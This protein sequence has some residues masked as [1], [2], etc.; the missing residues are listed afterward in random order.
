[1]HFSVGLWNIISSISM[2]S[3][4]L[5]KSE[6]QYEL[7]IRGR[8]SEGTVEELRRRLNQCFSAEVDVDQ[9]V[10]NDL[11]VELELEDC[12]EK[13]QD[14][15]TLTEEYDGDGKDRECQRLIA[16]LWH[17]SMRIERIPVAATA[18]DEMERKKSSLLHRTTPLLDKMKNFP[19]R[20]LSPLPDN[21]GRED[22]DSTMSEEKRLT[23]TTGLR[24]ASTIAT[25]NQAKPMKTT[26]TINTPSLGQAPEQIE[27]SERYEPNRI[28]QHNQ[29]LPVD[30]DYR[31]KAVPVYKWGLKFGNER[32]QSVAA[33]LQ[34]VEELRRSRGVSTREL[35]N[36]AVDL[37]SGSALVWYRSTLGRIFSWEELCVEMRIV[38]QSPD[39]EI[40]LQQE[41]FNRVQGDNESID[42][43]IASM[44]G[45]YSRLEEDIPEQTKLKQISH[46]LHPQL[47]DRIALFEVHTIE[48][49]RRLGRKAEMGRLRSATTRSSIGSNRHA[50]EPD[51]AYN[52]HPGRRENPPR[53]IASIQHSG[54]QPM[55]C[56][57]CKVTGHR[58]SD[59]DKKRGKF[60]FSCG[61]PGVIKAN[62]SKCHSKNV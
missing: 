12:E 54:K 62:C 45:L 48:Q 40:R 60:C 22:E 52:D 47:Q 1:M 19:Q 56:W 18:D 42:L 55:K 5:R 50:I 20:G 6:I 58:F 28:F 49:L 17:L 27:R 36:S 8:S 13:Y 39:H 21:Y 14:L 41:I 9:R 31:S 15:C 3:Y 32:G 11:D 29:M 59:C 4:H 25:G 23:R 61:N 26:V 43:F 37:F 34:R 44:E 46:N 30:D 10:V 38:F 2:N 35:F 33:F 53:R 51:L 16:R 24:A 57:N 7:K